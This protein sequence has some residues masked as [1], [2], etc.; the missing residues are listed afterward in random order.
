MVFADTPQMFKNS[1]LGVSNFDFLSLCP[2]R[3][4]N[5]SQC[6]FYPWLQNYTVSETTPF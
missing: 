2:F 3:T 5:S 4:E 1:H 6:Q